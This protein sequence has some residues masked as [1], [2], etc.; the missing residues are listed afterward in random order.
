MLATA[1]RFGKQ[2]QARSSFD[3]SIVVERAW[4][5]RGRLYLSYAQN[6]LISVNAR[7]LDRVLATD[8]SLALTVDGSS[9]VLSIP[10][11]QGSAIDLARDLAAFTRSAAIIDDETYEHTKRVLEASV[12]RHRYTGDFVVVGD[13]SVRA[14]DTLIYIGEFVCSIEDVETYAEAAASLPLPSGQLQA[15]LAMLVITQW[16]RIEDADALRRRIEDYEARTPHP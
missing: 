7:F 11:S 5:E 12:S 14:T 10:I 1:P 15:A 8:E 6:P 4:V 13:A 2:W 16:R 9:G 3:R